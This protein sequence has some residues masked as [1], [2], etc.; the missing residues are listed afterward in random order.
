MTKCLHP[1][2]IKTHKTFVGCGRCLECKRKRS[3]EWTIR[4]LHQAETTNIG[5][6]SMLTLTYDKHHIHPDYGLHHKDFQNFIKKLR[7]NYPIKI[8]YFMCGEY[9]PKTHRPHYHALIYGPTFAEIDEAINKHHLWPHGFV[10]IGYMFGPQM[11]QYVAQYTLKKQ[12][13][14]DYKLIGVKPPYIVASKGIGKDWLMKNK[15]KIL[16][17]K[18]IHYNDQTFTI[19]RYYFKQLGIDRQDFYQEQI[20]QTQTKNFSIFEQETGLVP[21][22]KLSHLGSPLKKVLKYTFQGRLVNYG[23]TMIILTKD[24]LKWSA[25]MAELNDLKLQARYAGKREKI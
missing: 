23:P 2:Y 17:Q 6:V 4:N 13:H 19:P 3:R 1:F 14:S 8:K 21:Y 5:N 11:V 25:K 24:Y 15:E 9:G 22:Y 10:H 20:T 16:K 12:K 7:N 18:K